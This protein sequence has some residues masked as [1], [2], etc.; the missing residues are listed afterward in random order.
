MLPKP[1]IIKVPNAIYPVF[2]GAVACTTPN[3]GKPGCL[4]F[5]CTTGYK[6]QPYDSS[7]YDADYFDLGSAV[8][9][10]ISA[11]LSGSGIFS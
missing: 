9:G 5:S 8:T 1:N 2:S 4:S 11:I 7:C 10:A 6:C 3:F